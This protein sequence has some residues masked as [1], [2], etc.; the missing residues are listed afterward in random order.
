MLPI[1]GAW[2]TRTYF[3][4]LVSCHI[5]GLQ[6][7]SPGASHRLELDSKIQVDRVNHLFAM[8][9][10]NRLMGADNDDGV[11]LVVPPFGEKEAVFADVLCSLLQCPPMSARRGEETKSCLREYCAPHEA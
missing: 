7:S 3:R 4:T 10:A 9:I 1:R 8:Y 11:S 6:T 2:A 5:L